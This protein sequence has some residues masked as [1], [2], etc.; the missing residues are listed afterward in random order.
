MN[1]FV[2]IQ[3]IRQGWLFS[4]LMLGPLARSKSQSTSERIK[5]FIRLAG[6]QG[7]QNDPRSVSFIHL[8][9]F[10]YIS[11]VGHAVAQPE[12]CGFDSRW[13]HWNFSLI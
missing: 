12:G 4:Y 3:Y 6:P 2:F 1:L 11:N 7:R 8:I 9:T 13:C 5:H 10:K